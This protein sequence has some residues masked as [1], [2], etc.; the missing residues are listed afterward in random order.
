MS[1]EQKASHNSAANGTSY[2]DIPDSEDFERYG[3][4]VKAGPDDVAEGEETAETDEAADFELDDLS[5]DEFT[6]SDADTLLT[7]EEED[8]LA[9]LEADF[10]NLEGMEDTEDAEATGESEFDLGDFESMP[11][12]DNGDTR[13][14]DL[15][16]EEENEEMPL[17][18][19]GE[20]L[21]VETEETG[22]AA[23][24]TP[25]EISEE[26]GESE[27]TGETAEKATATDESALQAGST[28]DAAEVE[29]LDTEGS[30][31]VLGV[32]FDLD[33][34]I[35]AEL[36][37]LALDLSQETPAETESG[38]P[39]STE[40]EQELEDIEELSLDG[41]D[42][43]DVDM[44]KNVET[45]VEEKETADEDF[46]LESI[47]GDE[48]L[49]DFDFDEEEDVTEE[50]PELGGE[51]EEEETPLPV[52]EDD[53]DTIDAELAS[54]LDE[55]ESEDT[56][57]LDEQESEPQEAGI[58]DT[59]G[60][61]AT[62]GHSGKNDRDES[63]VLVN[64]E[65]ELLSIKNE[66]NELKQEL[67]TLRSGGAGHRKSEEESSEDMEL[68]LGTPAGEKGGFFE[69]EE[70]EDETIALTGD[71][72]DHI[73]DTA[74][75][76][77]QRGQPTEYEDLD[78]RLDDSL[79][80]G[81]GGKGTPADEEMPGEEAAGEEAASTAEETGAPIE[82]ITLEDMTG[83]SALEELEPEEED[84][85]TE[86]GNELEELDL[87]LGSD[88]EEEA[89]E[90]PQ[91]GPS[92]PAAELSSDEELSVEFDDLTSSTGE[93]DVDALANLDMDSELADIEELTD[94]PNAE[95]GEPDTSEIDSI[96]IDL[97]G[98]EKDEA[99]SGFAGADTAVEDFQ[100]EL[101]EPVLEIPEDGDAEDEAEGLG[102]YELD[103]EE[104]LESEDEEEAEPAAAESPPTQ[105]ATGK[106]TASAGSEAGELPENLKQ[107]I[108]SVLSYMDQL[109]ESLPEEKIQ[110]FARSEHFEVYKRLFEELGLESE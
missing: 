77:E 48:P 42:S 57:S 92:E 20:L 12:G 83:E 64:I 66:L 108:R 11:A 68:S 101:G 89:V 59:E 37:D 105:T 30:D 104:E 81:A 14:G 103:L 72:L 43:L 73:L 18:L 65:K 1:D 25:E 51:D 10:S 22:G 4:W 47:P 36:E 27:A 32:D 74:E 62:A 107:E 17:E 2:P 76:T 29:S 102:G 21:S 33:E 88:E 13:T 70:D 26:T 41:L 99:E 82:E 100:P 86:G 60:V 97:P 79:S 106:A 52:V 58:A 39:V 19:D 91:E 87:D 85:E 15:D 69:D 3:V 98:D 49:E 93:N 54:V 67:A 61:M 46:D 6:P 50:L 96:E 40:S 55:E 75:F 78:L 110:E 5:D 24:E 8:A 94:E 84:Q 45:D 34:D 7:D 31:D 16:S 53:E 80:P 71:E 28:G 23:A 95:E 35:D 44:E 38:E 56:E 63:S 109:L 9:D 90:A